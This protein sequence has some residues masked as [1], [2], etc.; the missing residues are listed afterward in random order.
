[1]VQETKEQPYKAEIQALPCARGECQCNS[2]T[3]RQGSAV[4]ILNTNKCMGIILCLLEDLSKDPT[5]SME[6]RTTLFYKKSS[7]PDNIAEQL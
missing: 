2:P 1:M 6:Q 7:I 5:C 4:L 3:S